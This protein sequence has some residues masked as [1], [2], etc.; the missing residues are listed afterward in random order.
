M[1]RCRLRVASL[2][3]LLGLLRYAAH[4]IPIDNGLTDG[5]AEINCGSNSITVTFA[6]NKTFN[7]HVYVKVP[8]AQRDRR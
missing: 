3:L 4:A 8:S 2:A 5:V 7:G 6:T 1:A